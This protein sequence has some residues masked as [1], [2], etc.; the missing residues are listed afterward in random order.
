[1]HY[2]PEHLVLALCNEHGGEPGDIT[3]PRIE[4][5]DERCHAAYGE[6]IEDQS[7]GML[8]PYSESLIM[9]I[10]CMAEYEHPEDCVAAA[11]NAYIG[12]WTNEVIAERIA[13]QK[14][15]AMTA[16]QRE[17]SAGRVRAFWA[18]RREGTSSKERRQTAGS[19]EP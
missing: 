7:R 2:Q 4:R 3:W 11:Y 18:A 12:A 10:A 14:K 13:N 17:A 8:D 9:L 1:M 6:Y 16:A 19:R 5:M 15:P